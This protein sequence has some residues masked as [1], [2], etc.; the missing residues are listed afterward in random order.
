MPISKELT[1]KQL[2]TNIAKTLQ[3]PKYL[4]MLQSYG[5]NYE[6]YTN[7]SFPNTIIPHQNPKNPPPAVK[8]RK[9]SNQ[10]SPKNFH[11][12]HENFHPP[13]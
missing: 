12:W 11:P 7:I 3:Q 5:Y 1:F 8:Y 13:P 2:G 9:K 6:N 10:P 4:S